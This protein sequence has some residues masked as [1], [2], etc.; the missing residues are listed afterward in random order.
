MNTKH[1][2]DIGREGAR[3]KW[4]ASGKGEGGEVGR[5]GVGGVLHC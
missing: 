5:E 4:E 3:G 1:N 2:T